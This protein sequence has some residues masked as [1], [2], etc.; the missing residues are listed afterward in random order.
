M[1]KSKL[2]VVAH[3]SY[4][5]N[6]INITSCTNFLDLTLDS[7]LSWKTHI[8]QPS[9]K[10]NTACYIIRSL[11]SVISTWNLRTINFSYVHS[12]WYNFGG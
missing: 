7:T 1:E 10:Q 4:K 5:D 11:K 2:A 3:I 12:L 9:S 8:N 6:P